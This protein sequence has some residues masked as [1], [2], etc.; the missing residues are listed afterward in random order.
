[1]YPDGTSTEFKY[2]AMG[3]RVWQGEY[4]DEEELESSRYFVWDGLS[5]AEERD[6]ADETD[7]T[8][9][10][11]AEGEMR[12]STKYF[13]GRD[14]LGSVREVV[15]ASGAVVARYDYDPYGRREVVSQ[16]VAFDWGFTGHYYHADSGLHLAPFRAYHADLGRWLSRDPLGEAGGINLYEYALSN[17]VARVLHWQSLRCRVAACDEGQRPDRYQPRAKPGV[18]GRETNRRAEGPIYPAGSFVR[19][20]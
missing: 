2:D 11:F 10:Y 4:D 19:N 13:Y 1:V 15:D 12:G 17:P 9:Q 3:R 16:T 8:R 20:E 7:V 18:T 14:H 6:G 5:I